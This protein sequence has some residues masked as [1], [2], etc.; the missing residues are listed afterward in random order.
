MAGGSNALVAVDLEDPIGAHL[1]ETFRRTFENLWREAVP[2]RDAWQPYAETLAQLPN[3][4]WFQAVS[5]RH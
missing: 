3:A 4:S 5:S 1:M 2:A